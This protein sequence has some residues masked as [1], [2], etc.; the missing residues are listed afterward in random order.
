MEAGHLDTDPTLGPAA[1]VIC[2]GLQMSAIS[3]RKRDEWVAAAEQLIRFSSNHVA[4]PE[5]GATGLKV[6]D[7]EYGVGPGRGLERY[8][9][10]QHCHCFRAVN[11]QRAGPASSPHFAAQP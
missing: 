1:S 4:C 3:K 8:L 10:C 6:Q 7:R 2:E 5:C 9:L 11:L